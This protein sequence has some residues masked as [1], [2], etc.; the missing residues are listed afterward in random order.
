VI[1]I[2]DM[3]GVRRRF[4]LIN[5]LIILAN[6]YIF[7]VY[8][9]GQPSPRALDQFIRAAG[10]IPIEIISGVDRPPLAPLGI[11]YSTLFTSM[12]LHG[13]LLHLG[14]NMLFLWVFGDNVEDA[15]GHLSYAVFYTLCGLLAGF[16]HIVMNMNSPVPSIGASGAIAGVLG[17]YLIMFPHASIRTLM[18]LGPFIM[19]PRI[20]A[21]FLI[22]FWFVTQLFSGLASLE[23]QTEQTSG[24]AFWAHIGGFVAGFLLVQLFRPRRASYSRV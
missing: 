19:M 4:P 21:V 2:S 15:F 18:F 17:G 13:G 11:I 1:P 22:G 3:P 7:I 9:L 20:S 8:E 24:V 14:S 16:A 12:F 10:V 5:I 6:V 23:V